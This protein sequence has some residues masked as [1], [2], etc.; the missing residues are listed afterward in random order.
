MERSLDAGLIDPGPERSGVQPAHRARLLMRCLP[1]LRPEFHL[2][3]VGKAIH[4]GDR[5]KHWG[6]AIF[7]IG[8]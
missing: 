1:G 6:V 5:D 8:H 7:A 2:R 4:P 3:L